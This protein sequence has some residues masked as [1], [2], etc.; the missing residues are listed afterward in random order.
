MG[1]RFR[2]SHEGLGVGYGVFLGVVV[3][4]PVGLRA[5]MRGRRWASG[6]QSSPEELM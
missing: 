6:A 5:A 1:L 3:G 2:G 4:G